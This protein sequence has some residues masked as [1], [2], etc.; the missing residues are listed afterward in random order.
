ME[1][2]DWLADPL[3]SID[4]QF[5][6]RTPMNSAITDSH[7]KGYHFCTRLKLEAADYFCRQLLGMA[8]I[9]VTLGL[10]LLAHRQLKWSLDIFF[11]ELV[12]AHDMALQEINALYGVGWKPEQVE[13]KNIVKRKSKVPNDLYDYMA[14]GWASHW[15]KTVRDLRN[16][17]AHR[18]YIWTASS[19]GGSGGK[20][21]D[22]DHHNVELHRFDTEKQSIESQP[23]SICTDYLKNMVEHING[24]WT[25]MAN[26][27]K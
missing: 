17:G 20:P 9:P 27:F 11:F 1:P 8:Q 19:Q 5:N 6:Y 16:T 7:W 2:S 24:I 14:K 15:F 21:W 26:E 23:I 10:P 13:W 18:S 3:M 22:Y 12:S 25:R 4:T